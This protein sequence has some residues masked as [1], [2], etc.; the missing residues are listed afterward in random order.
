MLVALKVMSISTNL[1][2]HMFETSVGGKHAVGTLREKMRQKKARNG[3]GEFKG[4]GSNSFSCDT[5]NN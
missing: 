4:G 2:D 3:G 1:T 5:S